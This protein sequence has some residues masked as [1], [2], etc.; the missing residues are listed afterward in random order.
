MKTKLIRARLFERR[1]EVLARYREQLAL[2]EEELDSR[3]IEMIENATELW[4]A[5][6]LSRLSDV[7]A[8]TLAEIVAA[9]KRLDDGSYGR[10]IE[11]G[12]AV[13]TGRLAVL[14]EAATCIDC[15]MDASLAT[16]HIAR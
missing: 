14:P 4:D 16:T 6:V 7:D 15:A 13:G 5:Q 10:C 3:E 1:H 2:V 12:V 9:I 11:C 8:R